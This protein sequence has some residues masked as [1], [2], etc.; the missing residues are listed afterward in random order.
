MKHEY[1]E[2]DFLSDFEFD[3][4]SLVYVDAPLEGWLRHRSTGDWFAFRTVEL[5][6]KALVHWCLV[7]YERPQERWRL[8]EID[9]VLHEH[10]TEWISVLEDGRG[11][12]TKWR[13]IITR[14][15]LDVGWGKLVLSES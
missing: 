11:D 3:E 7:P 4:E 2:E 9:R 10:R 14:A 12:G 6:G 13:V 1:S 8:P 15:P 5:L